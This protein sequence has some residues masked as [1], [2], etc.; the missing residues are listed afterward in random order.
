MKLNEMVEKLKSLE[1]RGY[2]DV[3]REYSG[4]GMFGAT[5]IGFVTGNASDVIAE[6]GVRGAKTDNL[7]TRTIVYW[8]NIKDDGEGAEE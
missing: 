4:R 7:G 6:A 1:E 8:P 2:G 5:C 3:Y